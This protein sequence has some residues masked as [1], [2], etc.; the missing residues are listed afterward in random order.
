MHSIVDY[1]SAFGFYQS[2]PQQLLARRIARAHDPRSALQAS[3]YRSS[4][5]RSERREWRR[6]GEQRRKS[7]QVMTCDNHAFRRKFQRE[8]CVAVV[9]DMK[10][11]E[12]VAQPSNLSWIRHVRS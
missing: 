1:R 10:Q 9:D 12:A 6:S 7:I 3:E 11:V 8:M 4:E 5:S 2:M